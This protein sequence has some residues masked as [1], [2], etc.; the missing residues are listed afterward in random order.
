M[1][2]DQIES[3]RS[4]VRMHLRRFAR[5]FKRKESQEHFEDY[6]VGLTTDLKRK[7]IEPIALAQDVAVT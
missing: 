1:T 4:A 5:C 3:L 7:S 2:G 6:V